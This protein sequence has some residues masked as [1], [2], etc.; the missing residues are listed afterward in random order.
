MRHI[1]KVNGPELLVPKLLIKTEM[2]Y[3]YTAS[4]TPLVEF[5]LTST[6]EIVRSGR[7]STGSKPGSVGGTPGS[8]AVAVG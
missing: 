4:G 8:V 5:M 6:E 7:E 2:E 1:L 3:G